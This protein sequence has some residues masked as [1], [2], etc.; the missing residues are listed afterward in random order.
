MS[1]QNVKL[2]DVNE[3]LAVRTGGPYLD[4][5]LRRRAEDNRAIIEGRGADYDP[6]IY[7]PETR[8]VTAKELFEHVRILERPVLVYEVALNDLVDRDILA[9]TSVDVLPVQIDISPDDDL[10]V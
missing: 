4:R 2:Y 6:P 3:G 1:L 7:G 5:E 10:E 9:V 8:L